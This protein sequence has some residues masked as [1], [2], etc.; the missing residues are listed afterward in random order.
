[1]RYVNPVAGGLLVL[2]GILL[3]TDKLQKLAV[4]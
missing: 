4:F 2:T 3:M 1:L